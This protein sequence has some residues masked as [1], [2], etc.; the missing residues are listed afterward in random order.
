[1]RFSPVV[2]SK[3]IGLMNYG[4]KPNHIIPSNMI[5]C[6]ETGHGESIADFIASLA[7]GCFA[8]LDYD[9]NGDPAEVGYIFLYVFYT[10]KNNGDDELD[11]SSSWFKLWTPNGTFDAEWDFF[12]SGGSKVDSISGGAST[13]SY[14]IFEI[15]EDSDIST[16]WKLKYEYLF[17]TKSTNLA[18]IKSGFYDVYMATLTIDSYHYSDEGDYSWDSPEEGNT[19]IYVNITLHNSQDNDESISTSPWN[20]KFYTLAEG[21]TYK[22]AK[23]GIPDE[24]NPGNQAYWYIYF[25]IPECA[26][27]DKMAYDTSGIAPAQASFT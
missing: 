9:N 5:T 7:T 3:F 18:D 25:E 24:I 13:S 22:S 4:M 27:L 6:F 26:T 21:Y 19:Y 14:E 1:M 2:V 17:T 11:L 23:E 16:D 20:F 12:D 10:I 8:P 15:P